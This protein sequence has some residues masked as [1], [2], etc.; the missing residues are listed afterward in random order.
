M[1]TLY[2]DP[3]IVAKAIARLTDLYRT[4]PVV[5][6]LVET[7]AER[8]QHEDSVECELYRAQWI[9]TAQGSLLNA[10]GE[11]VG[12]PRLG[13]SDTLY[14]L[15][16]KARVRINRTQGT[17]ADSYHLIRLIAGDNVDI[18]Y[19][20][21]HPA[22]YTIEVNGADVDAA[23][24][25]KLLDAVRPAGVGMNLLHTPDEDLTTVFTLS[26]TDEL[27]TGDSLKG[28]SDTDQLTGGRLRGIL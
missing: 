15:W 13:R 28:F 20:P 21:Q 26:D 16:I 4:Q 8:F 11:L 1:A 22:A 25:Y 2:P 9:D 14:R 6:A 18:T 27:T 10:I 17:I 23:E 7:L 5:R 12:E 19:R 24:M 3:R